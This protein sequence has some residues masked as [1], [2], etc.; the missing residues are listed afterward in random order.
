MVEP[1]ESKSASDAIRTIADRLPAPVRA[2]T[3]HGATMM[4]SFMGARNAVRL[5]SNLVLTRL[6][7][8][9][10]FGV[11]GVIVSV[12]Y[13][14]NMLSDMGFT[15]YLVRHKRE[16]PRFL[17]VIWTIRLARS[18]VMSLILLLGA[19]LFASFFNDPQL[20]PAIAAS[21]GL[22]VLGALTSLAPTV[23]LRHQRVPRISFIEFVEHV[24]GVLVTIA[25]AVWLRS[26][27]AI[28]LGMYFN[29]LVRIYASY[30]LFD[31][32]RIGLAFDQEIARDMWRFAR[33][34]IPS[35]IITLILMQTDKIF[36]ARYFPMA[37][38]GL[39]MLA[40]S[41]A[42]MATQVTGQYNARILYP[43]LAKAERR[44]G[45]DPA[46]H[47][48]AS[49]RRLFLFFAF[50]L[51]GLI[52]G[53]ELVIRLLFDDR[54]LGAAFYLSI[55]AI[56]PLLKLTV[57][58]AE[59]FLVAKGYVKATLHANIVRLIWFA[60]LGPAAYVTLGPV[61]VVAALMTAEAP[62]AVYNW[63]RLRRYGALNWREEGWLALAAALGAVLGYAANAGVNALIGR[64]VIPAF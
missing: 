52:A 32:L 20:A 25:A 64:G 42:E 44:E 35:S 29:V 6:L 50:G 59:R 16:D 19:G 22:P 56:R 4:I 55:V 51:G 49:R 58:P 34:I 2:V 5:G 7:T 41:L 11:V 47:Y 10:A 48:Y 9:E 54:Y 31:P 45:D 38:L 28:I 61:G 12:N 37:E 23:A 21:A 14:L 27:W 24:L 43:L 36:M 26:Y 33:I 15:A 60:A 53:G 13:V 40:V 1:G 17:S 57:A 63:I 39:F 8:P 30:R 3:R 18:L 62:V 46:R